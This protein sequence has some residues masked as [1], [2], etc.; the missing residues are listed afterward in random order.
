[1]A[2]AGEILARGADDP[3]A[4]FIAA[5]SWLKLIQTVDIPDIVTRWGLGEGESSV[6]A[7]GLSN[8]GVT[9]LMDDME[10]RKCAMSLGLEV[11]GT[12]G[13]VLLA[14][15]S[16]LITDARRVMMAMS[17]NGLYL[18]KRTLDEALRKVGE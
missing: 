13:I 10:G 1:M 18:S 2:V 4:K 12:L 9:L 11:K 5:T 14:K 7:L 17:M 16:G 3:T 8:P 15:K 6:I